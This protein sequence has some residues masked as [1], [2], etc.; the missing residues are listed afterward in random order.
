MFSDSHRD[1]GA[2]SKYEKFVTCFS[3]FGLVSPPVF[4]DG[5]SPAV[6]FSFDLSPKLHS[7]V[8]TC[9]STVALCTSAVKQ[10]HQWVS[11]FFPKLKFSFGNEIF[12]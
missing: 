10:R 5:I 11:V 6:L 1:H 7:Q 4:S 12:F 2:G 8:G 3:F 9:G